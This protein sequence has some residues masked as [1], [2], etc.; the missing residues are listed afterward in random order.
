MNNPP[1]AGR[2]HQP[3]SISLNVKLG[4]GGGTPPLRG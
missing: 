1:K 2:Q 3:L 4:G